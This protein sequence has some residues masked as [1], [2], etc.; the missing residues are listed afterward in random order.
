[1]INRQIIAYI[2]ALILGVSIGIAIGYLIWHKKTVPVKLDLE[3]EQGIKDS[4]LNVVNQRLDTIS[5]IKKEDSIL[6]SRYDQV[7]DRHKK[8]RADGI[9]DAELDSLLRTV[10]PRGEKRFD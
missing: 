2:S 10:I 1:M 6:E 9:D 8:I 5:S 7:N 3:K 4:I